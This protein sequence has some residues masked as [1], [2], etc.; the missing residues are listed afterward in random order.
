MSS[1]W[2]PSTGEPQGGESPLNDF[3]GFLDSYEQITREYENRTTR[4][5]KFKFTALRVIDANEPYP[6]PVTDITLPYADPATDRGTT[7]WAYWAASARSVTGRRYDAL[8]ALEKKHQRW[9]RIPK[10]IRRQVEG[11][12]VE[13]EAP[14]W[15]VIEVEGSPKAQDGASNIDYLLSLAGGKTETEFYQAALEDH[16]IMRDPGLVTVLTNR[17]FI[18]EMIGAGKLQRSA[19]GVLSRVS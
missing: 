8:D 6:Y 4:S 19:E 7:R 3:E 11:E 9:K 17:S 14:V 12:W 10:K 1:E 15:H 16:R 2:K 5:V 13:E 18:P